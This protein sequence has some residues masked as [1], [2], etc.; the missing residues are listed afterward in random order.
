VTITRTRWPCVSHRD[1][2]TVTLG[3]AAV[4]LPTPPGGD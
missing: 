1:G 4:V 2:A 3:T